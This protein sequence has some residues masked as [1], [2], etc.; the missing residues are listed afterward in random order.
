MGK[1]DHL[2]PHY[3]TERGAVPTL[4]THS[5]GGSRPCHHQSWHFKTIATL[6]SHDGDP[7]R[8]HPYPDGQSCAYLHHLPVLIEHRSSLAS[9]ANK[10]QTTPPQ[11]NTGTNSDEINFSE[12]TFIL[13]PWYNTAL[14]QTRSWNA[15]RGS[16]MGK[17]TKG[18]GGG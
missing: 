15:T 13:S 18:K 7:Q 3:G 1:G 6:C 12:F 10:Q 5:R 9:W 2:Q 14:S 8:T 4:P 17:N 16:Q 11:Q